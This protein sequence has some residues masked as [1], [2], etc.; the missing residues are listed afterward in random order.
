MVSVNTCSRVCCF[1]LAFCTVWQIWTLFFTVCKLGLY[2]FRFESEGADRDAI[3]V[4]RFYHRDARGEFWVVLDE[5]GKVVGSIG[6]HKLDDQQTVEIRKMYL[7]PEA[8]GKKLG[9][10]LLEVE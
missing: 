10:K 3:E 4:E 2:S 5:G 9:R 7:L 8:R 6:Y 1:S